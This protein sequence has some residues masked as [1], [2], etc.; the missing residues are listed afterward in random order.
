MTM[1]NI[2]RYPRTVRGFT[3]QVDYHGPKPADLPYHWFQVSSEILVPF[4]D[5]RATTPNMGAFRFERVGYSQHVTGELL[6]NT[7]YRD[8][9]EQDIR[10][11][12][13][14][15]IVDHYTLPI[16]V[17]ISDGINP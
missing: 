16:D 1:P 14:R 7:G 13:T 10:H 12:L 6:L 9:L 4:L 17:Q 11:R 3:R 5:H 8:A 15:E 2:I